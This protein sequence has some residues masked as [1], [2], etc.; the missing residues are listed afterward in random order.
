[1]DA[2]TILLTQYG[3]VLVFLWVLLEQGGMPLPAYPVLLLAGATAG[4]ASLEGV[5]T[6]A[7]AAVLSCALADGFWFWIGHRHGDRV[8]RLMC[9][10]SLTPQACV[11]KTR[12]AFARWGPS[13][14]L[15]AKFVPAFSSVSSVV[16]GGAGMSAGLFFVY[17]LCG[18][19]LWALSG[20]LL[21]RWFAPLL[22]LLLEVMAD[23]GRWGV[24]L[25]AAAAALL[26]LRKFGAM[27]I[28]AQ[29][30]VLPPMKVEDDGM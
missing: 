27:R 24:A 17:D 28:K 15:V 2:L 8:L 29:Q 20:L 14:L 10:L 25:V 23:L 4:A 16:A 7:L 13:S 3:V 6:Y 9:A 5:L 12:G 11:G 30:T 22:N 19:L 1:M 26:L 21:G 18:A